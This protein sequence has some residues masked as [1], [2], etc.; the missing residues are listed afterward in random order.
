VVFEV[1]LDLALGLDHEPEA[2][3]IADA[4]G[5]QPDAERAG[6]PER[7]QETRP[8]AEFAQ[9]LLRPGEVVGLFACG[10]LELAAQRIVP[11]RERL[12][13]VERLGAH[14]ANMVDAHQRAGK[15][16]L[17][18]IECRWW[19]GGHRAGAAGVTGARQRP[20]GGVGGY[21]QGIGCRQG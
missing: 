18:V 3:R 20:Q 5:Q 14:L 6:V 10:V 16:A 21:Q 13:R 8:R 11:R 4:P 2:D 17:R 15:P 1:L 19:F 9:A 12:R 7:V